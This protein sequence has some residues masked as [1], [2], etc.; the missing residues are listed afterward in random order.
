MP[1]R[2]STTP[3]EA[4][5]QRLLQEG[6]E[7]HEIVPKEQKHIAEEYAN[8]FA[9][10]GPY[11][12]PPA[13]ESDTGII[14][15]LQYGCGAFG[16]VFPVADHRYALKLTRDIG[17]VFY[18]VTTHSLGLY[19]PGVVSYHGAFRLGRERHEGY[20]LL[21]RDALASAGI[22]DDTLAA[23][24]TLLLEDYTDV[25]CKI[26]E[27]L[28]WAVERDWVKDFIWE[29]IFRG[30]SNTKQEESADRFLKDLW[31]RTV[32]SNDTG[33]P[34]GPLAFIEDLLEEMMEYD[35]MSEIA[36]S[37]DTLLQAGLVVCDIHPGNLGYSLDGHL[38]I[39]DP[40]MTVPIN[41]ALIPMPEIP[42]I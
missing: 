33:R 7:E 34:G 26:G 11:L 6:F 28:A 1:R 9:M 10:L 24:A 36:T 35:M 27:D 4:V 30:L 19:V 16:C 37:L 3:L 25:T 29:T 13:F 20:Y 15:F 18:A 39:T 31:S 5:T 32:E 14:E 8:I 42:E 17:E 12:T 21:I 40:G 38:V 22:E 2:H 41:P 23:G